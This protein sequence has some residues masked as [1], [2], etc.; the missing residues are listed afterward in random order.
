MK[1]RWKR[2]L[3]FACV[4]LLV[5]VASQM[6]FAGGQ[7]E[8]GREEKKLE[9]NSSPSTITVMNWTFIDWDPARVYSNE[10]RV[11]EN[12][13]E[14]LLYLDLSGDEDKILPGLAESFEK[15]SDGKIWTFQLRRGVKFSN[16]EQFNAESVK[17]SIDYY[18]N[19]GKGPTFIWDPV[20]EVKII[21]DYTVQFIC[22]KATPV[23]LLVSSQYGSYMLPKNLYTDK[24]NSWFQKGNAIGTGPYKL[25]S[26]E[27]GVRT[28]LE[29]NDEYWGGWK[30]TNYD[31]VIFKVVED[32][33]TRIQLLKQGAIDIIEGVPMEYL[34]GLES[35][36]DIEVNIGSSL[37]NIFYHMNTQK[38]PTDDINVRKAIL[39]A[40]DLPLVIEKFY[41]KTGSV[42]HGP[43]PSSIWGFDETIENYSY[44]LSKAKEIIK[45]SKYADQ[46]AK[47]LVQLDVTTADHEISWTTSLYIQ[48]ALRE[49][50]FDVVLD[51]TPWPAI[52]ERNKN[53]ED[54]PNLSQVMWWPTYVTPGDYFMLWH[55]EETP[56]WNWSYYYNDEFDKLLEKGIKIEG[57]NRNEAAKVYNKLQEWILDEALAICAA[58]LNTVLIYNKGINGIKINPAY[59]RT[60]FIHDLY[61]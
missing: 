41:G 56:L 2:K 31:R 25:V 33:T 8:G 38:P 37:M 24:D 11:L 20:T 61:Y 19:S 22:E 45:K 44:N 40:I 47:G 1:L 36:P 55:T 39:Y 58:D 46:F 28:I 32:P 35:I 14:H 30:S 15:S 29:K 26:W 27:K 52:W 7:Q 9:K 49:I 6:V 4:V 48:S 16:G 18:K 54:A 59:T 53:K 57:I 17:F 12:I 50:G 34:P 10:S 21:D 43:I 60:I 5:F 51:Q 23:D 13:Y 3:F 42:A